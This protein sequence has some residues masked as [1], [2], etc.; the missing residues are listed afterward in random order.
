MKDLG[1][2]WEGAVQCKIGPSHAA[3][4]HLASSARICHHSGS[5]ATTGHW[6]WYRTQVQLP[7]RKP[8]INQ[9]TGADGRKI[10]FIQEPAAWDGDSLHKDHFNISVQAEALRSREEEGRTKDTAGGCGFSFEGAGC[11]VGVSQSNSVEASQ[12]F[13]F[14]SNLLEQKCVKAGVCFLWG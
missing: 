12:W 7:A 8:I 14:Q 5:P 13:G 10:R 6:V 2:C 3:Q 1:S 11:Y 9:Q 4:K